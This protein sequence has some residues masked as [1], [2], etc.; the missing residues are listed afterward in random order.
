ML[1]L[2]SLEYMYTKNI[3][4]Y[5]YM[6]ICI[7]IYIYTNLDANLDSLSYVCTFTSSSY[8]S[9]RSPFYKS[10]F[11][12]VIHSW[13]SIPLNLRIIENIHTFKRQAICHYLNAQSMI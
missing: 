10:F 11:Y 2:V 7:Y 3:Y 5:I 1:V 8:P 4:I 6:Y 9:S 12:R 13:N